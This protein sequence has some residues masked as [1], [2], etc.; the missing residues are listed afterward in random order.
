MALSNTAISL[1]KGDKELK[2]LLTEKN[3]NI[4][5]QTMN[6]WLKD[7]TEENPLLLDKNIRLIMKHSDLTREQIIVIRED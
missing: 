3:N 5:R 7:G 4:S 6:L 1:I 2:N